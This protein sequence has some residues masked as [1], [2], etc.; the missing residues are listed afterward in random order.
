MPAFPFPY[1]PS[2]GLGEN[3]NNLFNYYMAQNQAEIARRTASGMS[4]AQIASM[5]NQQTHLNQQGTNQAQRINYQAI[6]DHQYGHYPYGYNSG[7][8]GS[9][10]HHHGAV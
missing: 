1:S 3:Y 7:Y 10:H 9:H 8:Y 4:D 6:H 5:L 2:L